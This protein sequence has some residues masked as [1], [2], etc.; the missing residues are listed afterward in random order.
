MSLDCCHTSLKSYALVVKP[1][2][3]KVGG[4]KRP[5]HLAYELKTTRV[6]AAAG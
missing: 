6:Q 2:T 4:L 1:V 3:V 5:S